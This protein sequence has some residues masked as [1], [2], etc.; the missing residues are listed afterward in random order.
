MVAVQ[1][2]ARRSHKA[3]SAAFSNVARQR[4]A[5]NPD[6]HATLNDGIE[7]L[8]FADFQWLDHVVPLSELFYIINSNRS[9]TILV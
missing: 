4:T 1:G 3:D 8:V 5:G 2:N 9:C 6:T 7:N